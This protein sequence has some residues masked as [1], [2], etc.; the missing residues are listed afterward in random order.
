MATKLP[1]DAQLDQF[2]LAGVQLT[3]KQSFEYLEALFDND[4]YHEFTDDF[5]DL[6][7]LHKNVSKKLLVMD[8]KTLIEQGYS[9]GAIGY[10]EAIKNN[11][12]AANGH[13]SK[14]V[15]SKYAL[16][17]SYMRQVAFDLG[18]LK[19]AADM[20]YEYWFDKQ[21]KHGPDASKFYEKIIA[22]AMSKENYSVAIKCL[23]LKSWEYGSKA[24]IEGTKDYEE[25]Q[26]RIAHVQKLF[27]ESQINLLPDWM[28]EIQNKFVPKKD[29][30]NPL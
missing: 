13:C 4:N 1:Y 3:K 20:N 18:E 23:E 30:T 15:H 19:I 7:P 10:F 8:Y 26:A 27:D 6:T 25:I 29:G 11:N 12:I 9:E 2:L 17:C 24:R 5:K 22:E 14:D 21:R 16:S 28:Q